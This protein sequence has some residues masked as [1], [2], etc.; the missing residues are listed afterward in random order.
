MN[1][2]SKFQVLAGGRIRI[3][4]RVVLLVIPVSLGLLVVTP[5]QGLADRSHHPDHEMAR[6]LVQ[7]GEI[8]PLERILDQHDGVR[9]RELLE[10]E[11]EE[12]R[13]RYLYE[14]EVVDRDGRVIKFELDAKTGALL[15][16]KRDK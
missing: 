16:E 5:R 4:C 9:G 13:G 1:M 15:R 8:L 11:L 6:R 7:S 2:K 14:I 3:L 10:V 12:K